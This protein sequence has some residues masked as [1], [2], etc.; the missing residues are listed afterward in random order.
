MPFRL[1]K[2]CETIMKPL[3]ATSAILLL[4]SSVPAAAFVRAAP[5]KFSLP[6]T[7]SFTTNCASSTSAIASNK[8]TN[9]SILP[10][11]AP[12]NVPPGTS[13]IEMQNNVNPINSSCIILVVGATRGIGLEFVTQCLEKG[14]TVIA[15]YRSDDIPSTIQDLQHKY[16]EN[17]LRSIRLD[18][19]DESS[20]E[21]AAASYRSSNLGPLTHIIHNAGVY[22]PGTSFDGVARGSRAVSP[23]VT[24]DVLMQTYEINSVAPLLTAQNF[25]PLMGKRSDALYPVLAFLS[26]KVGSVD[27]N[28]S[29]GAYAYRSSKSALNNIAKSLSVDLQNEARVVLLHPGYVKTDM[30][31]G[32]GFIDANE[33]VSGML[34]AVEATDGNTGFRFVDFKAC[35]IPW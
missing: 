26:S 22:L 34:N 13:P 2:A 15:T 25:V 21:N 30:T 14:A 4:S 17:K 29:G 32:K 18:V 11:P 28:G 20:I 31:G 8:D 6:H 33:S 3:L 19:C 27:D 9:M 35:L 1:L 5:S 23:K 24:K 7:S 16:T 10:L 12:I